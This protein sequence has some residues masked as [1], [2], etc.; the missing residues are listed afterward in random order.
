MNKTFIV[1]NVTRKPEIRMTN[2]GKQVCNFT[3]AVNRRGRDGQQEADFFR[4]SAWDRMA[5]NCAKY[6]DKGSKVAVVGAVSVSIYTGNDGQTRA[7]LDVVAHD[8]EF[9]QRATPAQ[10]DDE[11]ESA[12]IA[13][14]REAIQNEPKFVQ[15]DDDEL[16]FD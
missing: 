9:V 10:T 2:S 7:N 16:P 3:V 13:Q 6:L 5:E 14:E 4:V 12:Y 1:G 11:K 15:V 8:V